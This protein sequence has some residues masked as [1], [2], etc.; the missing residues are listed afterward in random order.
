MGDGGFVGVVQARNGR[1][2]VFSG[3]DFFDAMA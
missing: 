2:P 3:N 1:P